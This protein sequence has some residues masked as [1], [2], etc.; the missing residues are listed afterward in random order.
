MRIGVFGG[1]FNPIHFGHLR[2]A[3]EVRET[4]DLERV[5]FVPSATPP[6]KSNSGLVSAEHRF[7]MVRR[8]IAGNRH[9]QASRI[10]VDR[11]GRSYSVDTITALQK[12]FPGSR[13]AFILGLDAFAE[14]STWRDMR[15]FFGLCDVIVTSRPP[16]PAIDL[17]API[18]IV[19]RAEFCYGRKREEL[20]HESGHRVVF[21]RI[22]DLEISAT[23][24]RR[25]CRAGRSV[26]YLVPTS[27]ERYITRHGL[28]RGRKGADL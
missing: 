17:M 22:S 2:S 23:E 11:P 12:R 14:I 19:A 5:V 8:A 18:P 9:F 3:E 15:R 4:Q 16:H 24:L 26:R 27:V 28:Y 10:E 25:F 7:E 13:L 6:H 21:Q 1:T 20:A